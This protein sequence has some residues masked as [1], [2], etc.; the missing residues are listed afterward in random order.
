MF[1]RIYQGVAFTLALL[2]SVSNA[3]MCSQDLQSPDQI[4][5]MPEFGEDVSSY[6]S[7][8]MDSDIWS[9]L[10]ETSD[11]Y[12][13]TFKQA[14]FSGCQ[15]DDSGVGVY[16]GSPD[17][18]DTFSEFFDKVI[19]QYHKVDSDSLHQSDMDYR[20]LEGKIEPFEKEQSALIKSTRIRVAR[21]LAGYPFGTGM[22][23]EQRLE[24]EQKVIEACNSF[25]GDLAGTYYSLSTMSEEDRQQLVEDHFLFK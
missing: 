4:T 5:S 15:N 10:G 19:Q 13:F 20:S 6:L 9:K 22:T 12:G 16:A 7:R 17:S 24:I 8:N 23:R 18:Y 3:T 11:A 25:E 1:S 14:I 21:N 2:T